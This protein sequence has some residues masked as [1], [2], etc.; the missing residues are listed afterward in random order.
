[1]KNKVCLHKKK[2]GS[3]SYTITVGDSSPNL[4]TSVKKVTIPSKDLTF[5]L[6]YLVKK[7]VLV[8]FAMSI[9]QLIKIGCLYLKDCIR[10]YVGQMYYK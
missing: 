6:D 3:G 2:D 9:T 5:L 7:C 1:M 10:Q 4:V 8:Y